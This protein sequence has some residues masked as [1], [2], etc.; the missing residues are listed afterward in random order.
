MAGKVN[1]FICCR[2]FKYSNCQFSKDIKKRKNEK[3]E[4]TEFQDSHSLVLEFHCQPKNNF[5]LHY[6]RLFIKIISF[7]QFLSAGKS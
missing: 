3:K 2:Q 6:F 1:S 4:T 5:S 7:Y